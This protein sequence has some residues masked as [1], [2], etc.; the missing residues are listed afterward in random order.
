MFDTT[1]IASALYTTTSYLATQDTG[2][3]PSLEGQWVMFQVTNVIGIPNL[4]IGVQTSPDGVSWFDNTVYDGSGT[5]SP[6]VNLPG[7]Y[8]VLFQSANRYWRPYLVF[9][10]NDPNDTGPGSGNSSSSSG[11]STYSSSS[12]GGSAAVQLRVGLVPSWQF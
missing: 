10:A 7:Q 5:G 11:Q 1:A 3:S 9:Y 12:S 6:L 2:D 4:K 8:P